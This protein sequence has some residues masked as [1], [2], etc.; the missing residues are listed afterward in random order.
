MEERGGRGVGGGERERGGKGGSVVGFKGKLQV[1]IKDKMGDY[2][3]F[4]PLL[5]LFIYLFIFL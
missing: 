1:C 2:Y 5:P 4:P 3:I